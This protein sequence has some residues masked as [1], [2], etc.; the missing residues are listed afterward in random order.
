M[1]GTANTAAV[2]AFAEIE[3]WLGIA[4]N[5]TD[6]I[7]A[8]CMAC[9]ATLCTGTFA[10]TQQHIIRLSALQTIREKIAFFIFKGYRSSERGG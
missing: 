10:S 3:H 9:T 4:S 6:D 8:T 2:R 1:G 5:S 7:S